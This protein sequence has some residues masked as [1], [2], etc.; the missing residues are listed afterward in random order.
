MNS[1]A[2]VLVIETIRIP[3]IKLEWSDWYGWDLT[4]RLDARYSP[5]GTHSE[6]GRPGVYEAR[7]TAIQEERLTI[8]KTSDLRM[9]DSTGLSKGEDAPLN[10]RAYPARRNHFEDCD[11]MGGNQPIRSCCG[12][13]ASSPLRT[14]RWSPQANQS[15]VMM[16]RVGAGACKCQTGLSAKDTPRH[17]F[18]GRVGRT[19]GFG[20]ADNQARVVASNGEVECAWLFV[21]NY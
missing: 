6:H 8:G 9:R 5:G 10:W 21:A 15:H 11:S 16:F 3:E 7:H 1:Q 17:L 19:P 18:P 12:G 14:I 13:A 20:R 4:V 2:S